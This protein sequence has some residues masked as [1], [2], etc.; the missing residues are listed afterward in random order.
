VFN[1]N[2]SDSQ[3]VK[4][5]I[6]RTVEKYGSASRGVVGLVIA[7]ACR[8]GSRDTVAPNCT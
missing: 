3:S 8:T 6:E 4:I 5:S 2:A 1:Q 7:F